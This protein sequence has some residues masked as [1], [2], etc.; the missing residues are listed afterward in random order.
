M[1]IKLSGMISGLDT[2]SMIDELVSAY[3]KNK[4]KVYK[5][6]KTLSYKQDSW[7]ELNTKIY[8]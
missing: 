6:Q 2:D 7:K 3:S 4:D 8:K 1:S 5:K